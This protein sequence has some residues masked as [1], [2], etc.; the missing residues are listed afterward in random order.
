MEVNLSNTGRIVK[1]FYS[2]VFAIVVALFLASTITGLRNGMA[3]SIGID[4]LGIYLLH[5]VIFTI[6]VLFTGGFVGIGVGFARRARAAEGWALPSAVAAFSMLACAGIAFGAGIISG[7]AFYLGP[8]P[9]VL[10]SAVG[11]IDAVKSANAFA[12][13]LVGIGGAV[14]SFVG[15]FASKDADDQDEPEQEEK[16]V[17]MYEEVEGDLEE[18]TPQQMPRPPTPDA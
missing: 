17:E 8:A 11:A 13:I 9:A 14:L 3:E 6:S 4:E 1:R 16:V 15:M 5:G 18:T 7:L 12:Q 2:S 10:A